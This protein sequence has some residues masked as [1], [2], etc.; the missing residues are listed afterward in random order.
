MTVRLAGAALLFDVGQFA[1]RGGLAIPADHAAARQ[2]PKPEEPN[3]THCLT[4]PAPW[5]SKACTAEVWWLCRPRVTRN[6]DNRRD[7]EQMRGQSSSF[8]AVSKPR[9]VD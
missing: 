1:A 2:C 3:Q 7:S 9:P 8:R 5:Q 4:L 6:N